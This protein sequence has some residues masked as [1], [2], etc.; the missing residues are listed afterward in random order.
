MGLRM[1]FGTCRRLSWGYQDT[2]KY[3]NWECKEMD[4][5]EIGPPPLRR[6]RF[7]VVVNQSLLVRVDTHWLSQVLL[8]LYRLVMFAAAVAWLSLFWSIFYLF[9]SAGVTFR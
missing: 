9:M 5:G 2:R 4:L 3:V 1:P 7:V 8:F 6:T